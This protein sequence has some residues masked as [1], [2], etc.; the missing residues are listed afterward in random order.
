MNTEGRPGEA[1]RLVWENV[2]QLPL[3]SISNREIF[4]EM[5]AHEVRAGRLDRARRQRIVRYAAQL[6]LSAVET[7]AMIQD[8]R[9]E[10]ILSE[11]PLIREHALRLVEPPPGWSLSARL[12]AT[13][14]TAV[15][16]HLL[17]RACL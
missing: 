4:R 15:L 5:I 13:L 16:V 1:P 9:A 7:G 8:C 2:G 14:A 10:A 6:G 11:D 17:I 12:G 3:R